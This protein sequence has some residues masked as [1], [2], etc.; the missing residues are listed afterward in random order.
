MLYEHGIEIAKKSHVPSPHILAMIV[1]G[2]GGG[3][4]LVMEADFVLDLTTF[5]VHKHRYGYTEKLTPSEAA[6]WLTYYLNTPNSHVLL[7]TD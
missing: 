7:L 6:E 5:R 3:T 4:R 1:T 2:Q